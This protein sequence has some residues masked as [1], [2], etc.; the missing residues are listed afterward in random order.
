MGCLRDLLQRPT[1]VVQDGDGPLP[2]DER[3]LRRAQ[4]RH[5]G[6]GP[7]YLA[8]RRAARGLRRARRS[9]NICTTPAP[10]VSRSA[11]ANK[12]AHDVVAANEV[13]PR[14]RPPLA[15]FV[16]SSLPVERP[17]AAAMCAEAAHV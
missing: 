12:R 4:G 3:A 15:A 17:D 2:A 10:T 11:A 5:A 14:T 1:R 6:D 8:G 9:V 7:A 16:W 13:S